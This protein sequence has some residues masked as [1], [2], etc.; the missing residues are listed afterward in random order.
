ME[1]R[2]T[3]ID[4]DVSPPTVFDFITNVERRTEWQLHLSKVEKLSDEPVAVGTRFRDFSKF[5]T[6]TLLVEECDAPN[7]FVY[8]SDGGP[9]QVRVEWN[10]EPLD[11]GTRIDV[12]ISFAP[13]SFMK[14]LWPLLRRSALGQVEKDFVEL[15]R[16]AKTL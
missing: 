10:L 12:S 1:S 14:L 8:G 11:T 6:S 15:Q 2:Q 3:T 9:F 16:V 13:R 4:V 7:R 5:G